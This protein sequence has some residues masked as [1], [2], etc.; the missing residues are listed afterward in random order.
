MRI[1]GRGKDRLFAAAVLLV[2]VLLAGGV[3]AATALYVL[4]I[5]WVGF[6]AASAAFMLACPALLGHRRWAGPLAWGVAFPVAL[7]LLFHSLLGV[8]LPAGW[9]R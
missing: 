6:L 9:L 4:A 5:Q 2:S 3:F 7:Y 1:A 8:Q